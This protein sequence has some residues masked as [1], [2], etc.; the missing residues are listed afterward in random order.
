M[1][2]AFFSMLEKMGFEIQTL[3]IPRKHKSGD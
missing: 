3:V 2:L 1:D